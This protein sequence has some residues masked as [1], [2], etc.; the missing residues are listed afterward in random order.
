MFCV[1]EGCVHTHD[2]GQLLCRHENQ[3]RLL[4]AHKNGD[5]S[6][7]SV[8]K[9][10]CAV[11]I[12]NVESHILDRC[13]YYA[14]KLLCRHESEI[15]LLFTYKKGDFG[16]IFITKRSYDALIS[17]AESHITDIV[18]DSFWCRHKTLSAI[19]LIQPATFFSNQ[20]KQK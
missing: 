10:S 5:F 2:T 3:I 12:S 15:R 17:K 13:S 6:A 9:R 20:L 11:P 1:F 8:T 7:I 18:F 19:V 14:G 16:A 4:F